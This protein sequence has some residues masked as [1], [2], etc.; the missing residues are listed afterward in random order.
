MEKLMC[1]FISVS[2]LPV[3]GKVI[4]RAV[5]DQLQDFLDNL[6]ALDP[7]KSGI[8]PSYG[9]EMALLG[10]VNSLHLS[11]DKGHAFFFFCYYWTI[12]GLS[13]AC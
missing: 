4:K 1:P 7:F 3:N 5:V 12:I 6:S 9:T 11:V 8:R 10:I 13:A 2:D